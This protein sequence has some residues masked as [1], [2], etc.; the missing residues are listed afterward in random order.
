MPRDEDGLGCDRRRAWR[1]PFSSVPGS[2]N[3]RSRDTSGRPGRW[4]NPRVSESAAV[5]RCNTHVAFLRSMAV[6]A[7]ISNFKS[8][9]WASAHA[10]FIHRRRHSRRVTTA[11]STSSS[12]RRTSPASIALA[13]GDDLAD[14]ERLAA[15]F[16]QAFGVDE[17]TVA[18]SIIRSCP[19]FISGTSTCLKRFIICPRFAGSGL[20]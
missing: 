6:S 20:R 9:T 4:R 13:A 10:T 3:R 1:R 15:Y 8:T 7:I 17:D 5:G 11:I 18:R 16:V 19:R 12:R 14:R 2:S